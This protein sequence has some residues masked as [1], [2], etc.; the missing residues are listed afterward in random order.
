MTIKPARPDDADLTL[1]LLP[2][3]LSPAAQAELIRLLRTEWTR[4]DYDWLEA[5]NGDYGHGLAITTVLARLHGNPI[6]TATFHYT[7]QHPEVAV[8]G[9]VLTHRSHRDRGLAGSVIEFTL[10]QIKATGCA[11]CLLGTTRKPRN[12][13]TQHGFAWQSGRVMRHAFDP[14][15]FEPKYF[16]AGQAVKIR[17]ATWADLPGLTLL[18]TQP[19]ATVCLDYPRGLLSGRYVSIE[20]C[21][22]NFPVV[23]YETVARGD[24]LSVLTAPKTGRVLGFGS[25]TRGPGAGRNHTA[26]VDFAA[27]DHYEAQ[28]PELLAHLLAGA[29]ELGVRH[30]QASIAAGDTAK[31]NCLRAAGFTAISHL[32]AALKLTRDSQDVILLGIL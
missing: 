13:Y 18:V 14:V 30:V 21:L 32:S 19:L 31:L 28:L 24:R 8:I 27:H 15:D 11:V 2:Y 12:V 23:W 16:A 4:T 25:I 20:R 26:M 9:S 22:S 3:P 10:E 1:E 29:R 6:A 7:R 5:M 17:P